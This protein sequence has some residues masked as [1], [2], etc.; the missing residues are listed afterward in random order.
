MTVGFQLVNATKR[1][2]VLFLHIPAS[3]RW[4]L[5]ADPIAATMIAWYMLNNFRDDVS[6]VPDDESFWPFDS[7]SPAE[8]AQFREVTDEIVQA[9]IAEDLVVDQ[10]I[11]I[12]DENDPEMYFRRLSLVGSGTVFHPADLA[13]HSGATPEATPTFPDAP[14]V[15]EHLVQRQIP[16]I[17]AGSEYI[18]TRDVNVL[19]LVHQLGAVFGVGAPVLPKGSVVRVLQPPQPA[20]SAVTCFPRRYWHFF[21]VFLGRRNLWRVLLQAHYTISIPVAT[22]ESAFTPVE[23]RCRG[24]ASGI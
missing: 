11:E 24:T 4:E 6:F 2:R 18:A 10:G 7:I 12:L 9:L 23:K 13:A 1:E 15:S 20:D 21:A 22:L 17:A 14:S 5:A 19:C 3:T 8:A 16:G